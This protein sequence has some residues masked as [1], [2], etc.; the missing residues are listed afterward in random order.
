MDRL[1][2]AVVGP[3][4]AQVAAQAL[5]DLLGRPRGAAGL[6]LGGHGAG[7][8]ALELADHAERRAELPRRAVAALKA[9]ARDKGGLQGVQG[10]A[11]RQTLDGGDL[12]AL[13]LHR[14]GEAGVDTLAVQQH[15]AGAARALVTAFL[16][17]R[18]A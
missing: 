11:G 3:A 12:A 1:D 7:Q 16:G 13:C 5:A 4:T 6:H 8:A 17:A 15:R 14:Q 2:D 10:V 9:V 18:Q